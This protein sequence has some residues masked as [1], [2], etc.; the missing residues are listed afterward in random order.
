[1]VFFTCNACGESLKKNAVEKHYRNKCRNCE[2]L[3]CIDCHKD[4]P[5]DTYAEHTKCITED[6]KYSAKGWTPKASAN[7]GERKQ[8]EWIENLRALT[9]DPSVSIEGDVRD[10]LGQVMEHENIPRKRAKFTNFVK[11][12]RRG[13]RPTTID[14]T[15]ELFEQALKKKDTAPE[16]KKEEESEDTSPKLGDISNGNGTLEEGKSKKK[17]KEK[18]R[19]KQEEEA[20]ASPVEN[21]ADTN[22]EDVEERDGIK[23]FKGT[24]K[25]K[26]DKN[27]KIEKEEI[28]KLSK[29][30]MEAENGIEDSEKS[31][32]KKK[33]K[34]KKRMEDESVSE[35]Q[36]CQATQKKEKA[37]KRKMEDP[38]E[39]N[40]A[41]A[42]EDEQPTPK[43]SKKAKFDWEEVIVEVLSKKG[44]KMKANKLKKR[45][46]GECLSRGA[47]GNKSEEKLAVKFDKRI[48]NSGRFKVQ[49]DFVSLVEEEQDENKV[50]M[51][52]G[53]ET[54]R[55]KLPD[56][57]IVPAKVAPNSPFVRTSFNEWE[58]ASL[59]SDN[60]TEKFRRLM[61]M[62][63]GGGALP[64][65]SNGGG[66]DEEHNPSAVRSAEK[67]EA[68]FRAQEEQFD[69]AVGLIK[70]RHK[71]L[72]FAS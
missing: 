3:T 8:L 69:K 65:M 60:D 41:E 11:N 38:P 16:A 66:G 25:F 9:S 28:A 46:V 43:K 4:F 30:Q 70:R 71:G 23:M 15:W 2:V 10:L 6:E 20:D 14:K 53:N 44:G 54:A 72:G 34:E 42:D 13:V 26:K 35:P 32:K 50:S 52:T 57:V 33:K 1:M 48:A 40:G 18:K 5:G 47:A 37:K 24:K 12:I 27:K 68:M 19:K 67:T 7:K 56:G 31:K 63:K 39:Q 45:V 55:G 59:G 17:K 58:K 51:V 64:A 21:G 36:V 62:K 61:G 29:D 49:K 22:G